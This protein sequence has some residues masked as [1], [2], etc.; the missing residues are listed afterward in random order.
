ML[1]GS[2]VSVI[3]DMHFVD[4]L[5]IREIARR[6]GCS[7]NTVR[8]WIRNPHKEAKVIRPLS[9]NG[10]WLSEN[11]LRVRALYFE[12]EGFCLPLQRE[13]K[14]RYSRDISLRMLERFCKRYHDDYIASIQ[15]NTRFETLPGD[16]M[17][18]DFGTKRVLINGVPSEVHLFVAKLGFSRRI[19]AKAYFCETCACWLDGIESAMAFFGGRPNCIVSDNASPLVRNPSGKK[20]LR[21]TEKY[22]GFCNYHCVTPKNTAIRKPRSKGKVENAVKYV[23]QNALP[24]KHSL[25]RRKLPK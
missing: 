20:E 14:D 22:K 4:G 3:R 21:F 6:I 17:Q 11:E 23:K 15:K 12:C 24:G 5:G 16:Q 9:D 18:I 8:N 25:P 1:D 13:L 7:R 19:F 10:Q 2:H